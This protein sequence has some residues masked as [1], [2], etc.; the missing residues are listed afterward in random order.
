M[1]NF[2]DN[3]KTLGS[4]EKNKNE[5][6]VVSICERK[7]IEYLD[8]RIHTKSKDSEKYIPTSKGF[9]VKIE[10]VKDFLE[11]LETI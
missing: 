7:D 11:L 8:V 5:N 3:Q 1:S 6:I 4:I 2:W 10:K 9:N